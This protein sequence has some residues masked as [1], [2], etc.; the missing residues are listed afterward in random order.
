M[1]RLMK[2]KLK[3]NISFVKL[4]VSILTSDLSCVG[5]VGLINITMG[6]V[7]H[8]SESIHKLGKMV[9]L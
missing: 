5:A 6:V 2:K 1:I 4:A 7:I 9:T 3:E 8:F